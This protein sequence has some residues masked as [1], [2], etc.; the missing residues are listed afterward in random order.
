MSL[1]VVV[2][3][4][5]T[6][7]HVYPGLAL[8]AALRERDH[9]V[10]FVGTARGMEARLV[11]EAGF[12]FAEVPARP[13]VR[14]LS[15]AALAG[16]L[17]AVAALGRARSL[18]RGADV[19]VG[20]GGYV[21]VPVGLA[22]AAARIP[23]VL[24]EQNTIPGLANRT[25]ARF[26]AAIALGFADAAP[27]LRS[28]ARLVTTG[29]PIR[30]EI[31]ALARSDEA[32]RA[33]LAAEARSVLGLEEGRRTIVVVGGSL[34]ALRLN[35]ATVEACGL[36]AARGD[37]QVVL[38]TGADHLE[39]TA[40]EVATAGGWTGGAGL[41]LRAVAFV[42]RMDLVYA[43]ADLL[44]SRAGA[45]TIAEECACGVPAILV[46]YPHAA[47]G[48]QDANARA[49]E[50]A[51]AAEVM[52]D[53]DVSGAA[54]AERIERMVGEPETLTRMRDRARAFGRPDAAA[55]VA[56]LVEQAAR[57]GRGR[58]AR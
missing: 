2:A 24:Q 54:L 12:A 14:S 3:G 23:L 15:P 53:G 25:L 42:A 28:R 9:E 8:A 43:V 21:S 38:V 10:L 22:A 29:N 5:G 50:R 20:V 39:S 37:L 1:Q 36:L 40:A 45:G 6:G 49:A 56:A 11:P 52:A 58:R 55:G 44:V 4:G 57:S 13:F 18:V 26:A 34:G 17:T 16:P 32:R 19:A 31:A 27:A 46:P 41:L 48:E 51:G 33:A 7:G 35:R 30:P 47:A